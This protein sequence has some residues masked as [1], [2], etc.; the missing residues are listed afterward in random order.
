MTDSAELISQIA[1]GAQKHLSVDNPLELRLPE[2]VFMSIATDSWVEAASQQSPTYPTK[3]EIKKY[4][5]D[6]VRE[7][8]IEITTNHKEITSVTLV[9]VTEQLVNY[10][11]AT[12]GWTALAP[13]LIPL[14]ILSAIVYTKALEVLAKNIQ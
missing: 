3:K 2:G 12:A 5:D 7:V 4:L 11:L 6:V 14:E 9:F 1:R 13:Y 10:L 8:L